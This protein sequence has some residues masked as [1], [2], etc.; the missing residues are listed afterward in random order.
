MKTTI[1]GGV[2]FLVP[3]AALLII[4]GKAYQVSMLVAQPIDR[5]IPISRFAG[6]ALVNVIAVFLILLVCYVA[7]LI[8]KR[9]MRGRRVEVLE[10]YLIDMVPGYA[11]VKGM[12]ESVANKRDGVGVL[13]PVVVAFD[14]Y[15]QIAFEVECDDTHAVLF[16]PGAPSTWSGSTVVVDKSRIR[17]LNLQTHKAVKFMRGMGR[18]TLPAVVGSLR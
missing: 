1:L 2:L 10:G 7:G 5:V 11:A 12:V 18:G 15:E 17:Y 4:V 16:L 6:I 13:K 3:F 8:A 14:D 9:G